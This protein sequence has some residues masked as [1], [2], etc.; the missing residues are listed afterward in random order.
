MTPFLATKNGLHQEP[1]TL[2]TLTEA[3]ASN[4]LTKIIKP[5][6]L[7]GFTRLLILYVIAFKYLV[8]LL[9]KYVPIWRY[10]HCINL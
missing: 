8:I 5:S 4:K 2:H 7:K 1:I 9:R 10:K 6:Q 3:P